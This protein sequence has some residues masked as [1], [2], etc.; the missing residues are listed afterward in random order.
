MIT[1][2]NRPEMGLKRVLHGFCKIRIVH[3][4]K[5]LDLTRLIGEFELVDPTSGAPIKKDDDVSFVNHLETSWIQ[6][7]E[8]YLNDK[9]VVELSIPS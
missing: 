1:L 3:F 7:I 5:I 2:L 4:F 9:Q 8:V 6:Q